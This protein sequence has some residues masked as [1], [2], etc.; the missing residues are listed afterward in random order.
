MITVPI[1]IAGEDQVFH[2]AQAS[3]SGARITLTSP[4][5]PEPVAVRYAWADNPIAPLRNR[6][7]LPASPFRT[8]AWPGLTF[9]ER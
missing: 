4:V 8:D 1:A 6:D 5:V 7:G 2:W 9:E 3:I